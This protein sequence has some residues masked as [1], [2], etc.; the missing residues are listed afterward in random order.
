[1]PNLTFITGNP[2]KAKYLA[3]FFR[4]PVAHVK[5]DLPEIQSL[6]LLEV[7]EDKARRAF[8][9]V[10]RPVL[11]EDVSLTFGSLGRLPGPFIKWFLEDLGNDGLCRLVDGLSDRRAWAEVAYAFCD[12]AGPRVFVGRTDGEIATEPRGETGFGWDAIFVP[13]GYDRTWAEMSDGEKHLTSMRRPAL[14]QLSSFLS[15]R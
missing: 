14:D 8:A 10:G 9:E 13:D 12:A 11:I 5:L 4:L 1:M 3:G 6:D 2:G 7:V 15:Q